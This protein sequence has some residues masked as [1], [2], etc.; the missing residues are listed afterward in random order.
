MLNI[1]FAIKN[2]EFNIISYYI[3]LL[4][5]YAGDFNHIEIISIKYI[6]LC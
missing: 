1:E 5:V 2:N 4:Y 3:I 6:K